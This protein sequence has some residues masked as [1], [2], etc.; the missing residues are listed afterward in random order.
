MFPFAAIERQ[1]P[2]YFAHPGGEIRDA[3]SLKD[4]AD[5]IGITRE[6]LTRHRA[7]GTLSDKLADRYACGLDKH[8]IELWP[9]EWSEYLEM[10]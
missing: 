8:P 9:H 7:I 6:T 3:L 2:E 1:F 4:L 10:A 5:R